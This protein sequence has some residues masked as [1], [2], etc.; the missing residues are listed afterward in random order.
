MARNPYVPNAKIAHTKNLLLNRAQEAAQLFAHGLNLHKQGNLQQAK[1]IY[2]RVLEINPKHFDALHLTGVIY[3]QTGA[4]AQAVDLITR[5]IKINPSNPSAH[6]NRGYAL[7]A[8]KRFDEAIINYDRAIA[9]NPQY[10]EAYCNRAIALNELNR[11]KEAVLSCEHAIAINPDYAE[12]HYNHGVALQRL[13]RLEEAIASFDRATMIR[14]SY[15]N[16]YSNRG[17]AFQALKNIPEALRSYEK[18]ISI[19]PNDAYVQWNKAIA[20]LLAGDFDRGWP[21]YEWRWKNNKSGLTER[22]FNQPLWLGDEDLRGKS[23]LIHSEQGLGDSIQFS[24]YCDLV[25]SKGARVILE[26]QGPLTGLMRE[27]IGVDELIAKGEKLPTFDYHCPLLSLPLAFKTDFYSIPKP[28][29]Y[30]NCPADKHSL[31]SVR[32]GP[33]NLKR[34]GLVWSGSLGHANDHNR[35]LHLSEMLEKL[36]QGFEYFSLQKEVRE[37]DKDCL[38]NSGI[39]HYGDEIIDFSDTAALCELMDLVVCVDTSVAHLAGALGK[40]IWLILPYVPDWRWMLEADTSPWYHSMRLY[41]QT[42]DKKYAT[43]LNKISTDI[44]YI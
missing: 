13:D 24:R 22:N 38:E 41:R 12:A 33:R 3:A 25:K 1:E 4:Q 20:L 27:L 36:P 31:W 44:R 26:I 11:L 8:L 39:R 15:V 42:M 6:Y 14:P 40:N 34:V 29:K 2:Q 7:L 16:A 21:L 30:L 32:L 23:I 9:L 35:S 19:D 18:A 5:A 17:A 37:V 43:V 28:Q 10:A